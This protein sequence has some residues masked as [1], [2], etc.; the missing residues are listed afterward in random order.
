[1][2][3]ESGL[4]ACRGVRRFTILDAM[5]LIVAAAAGLSLARAVGVFD[6]EEPIGLNGNL[7]D[8]LE[9]LLFAATAGFIAVRLRRPRPTLRRLGRQPGFVACMAFVV[10]S[11][12]NILDISSFA[13]CLNGFT[14]EAGIAFGYSARR[15]FDA[16]RIGPAVIL[17]WVV[18][19][20]S[21]A[22]RPERGWI[23]RFGRACAVFWILIYL[24]EIILRIMNAV[25]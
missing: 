2:L 18:L 17:A 13:I 5:I 11:A 9:C 10:A 8:L 16:F 25:L 19:S 3:V 22:W 14:A 6:A 23:D 7:T 12:C 24:F 21:T 15:I 1:M 20:L 4:P